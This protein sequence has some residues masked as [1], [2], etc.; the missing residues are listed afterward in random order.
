MKSFGKDKLRPRARIIKTIG[1]ELIS[2]DSVAIIELIKN[3][4]D[5]DASA[6]DITFTEPLKKGEGSIIIKDNGEGMTL[7]T[8]KTAWLEPATIIKKIKQKSLKGRRFLGEKGVGRFASARLSEQLSIITRAKNSN[9]L[10]ASIDWTK[11]NDERYLDEI[12]CSWEVEEEPKIFTGDE[13]GTIILLKNLKHDWE[14][15]DLEELRISLSRLINPI[16]YIKNFDINLMLPERFKKFSGIIS[17]PASLGSP[18]YKIEGSFNG[19]ILEM[20]YTSK[21]VKSPINIIEK[22]VSINGRS[23][24]CGPFKFEFRVWDR[25]PESLNILASET[26]STIREIKKDLNDAAGI[27]LYRDGFRVFPYGESE[28]DWLKLNLRRVNNPTLRISNN[29]VVGAVI[30][31]LDGNPELR[32]QSNRQGIIQT[33]AFEDLKE[34]VKLILSRLESKRYEERPREDEVLDKRGIFSD[35]NINSIIEVVNKKLPNDLETKFVLVQTSEKIKEGVK[36]IQEVLSRYRR[37]ATLGQILDS[38]LHEGNN[39]LLKIDSEILVL[40]KDLKDNQPAKEGTARNINEA[41][42]IIKDEE[43]VLSQL[44]KRLAPF[45][46]RKPSSPKDIIIEEAIKDIFQIRDREIKNLK[47]KVSISNTQTKLKIDESD[48]KIIINNL[49]LNSLYWIE[50]M[51][52]QERKIFVEVNKQ[53]SKISIIFSDNGPG[54]KEEDALFIFDPYFSTKPDGIG[55]GLTIAGELVTEYGGK[56]ELVDSGPLTGA[57]FR[58]VFEYE[59]NENKNI[60][61]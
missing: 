13:T 41:L 8:I 45:G 60:D 17:S 58:I 52:D 4:Y 42:E 61:D 34:I 20:N 21:N 27:S 7:D 22:E 26:S 48:L 44:F 30:I 19:P 56:L 10:Y 18:N 39:I 15:Q 55:L 46:G 6:V 35:M 40:Q 38:V 54:I 57:N 43:R 25:D 31:S 12:D 33:P 2:N 5:A 32:D 23:P 9:E 28:F 37:L 51:K 53:E 47:I 3:S 11:F 49:L 16:S 59:S 14:A 1:E 50:K 29:Q 24:L 36:K